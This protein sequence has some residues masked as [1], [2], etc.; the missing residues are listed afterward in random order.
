MPVFESGEK[1]ETPAY[2][3]IPAV[4]AGRS[5][6]ANCLVAL[7]SVEGSGGNAAIGN[8][9][10]DAAGTG[11]GVSLPDDLVRLRRK[12]A[13]HRPQGT[14]RAGRVLFDEQ[15]GIA[16]GHQDFGVSVG[17]SVRRIA[18]E[19]LDHRKFLRALNGAFA[20]EDLTLA[21]LQER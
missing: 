3:R 2:G 17:L 14:L 10:D 20:Q 5:T 15:S 1:I 11:A 4:R 13:G 18:F 8:R 21:K 12:I 19:F 6:D 7:R 16:S 9:Q